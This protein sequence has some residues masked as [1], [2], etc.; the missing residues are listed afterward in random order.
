MLSFP[1]LGRPQQTLTVRGDTVSGLS[2]CNRFD[3]GLTVNGAAV[4]I[5][6]VSMT[7]MA[8]AGDVMTKEAL[9]LEGLAQ[10]R[11][12]RATGDALSLL[13]GDGAVVLQFAR[14]SSAA[15]IDATTW[16]WAS[17]PWN[18]EPPSLRIDVN[19]ATGFTGCN[20]WFANVDRAEDRLRF[21]GVGQTKMACF[22][23][24]GAAEQQFLA[25]LARVARYRLENATL[26]LFDDRG[27]EVMRLTPQ[28][29]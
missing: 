22:G 29:R 4:R 20:R 6:N 24:A 18:A 11:S 14:M 8:C 9:F 12:A 7:E 26:Q 10:T 5:A 23:P 19:D 28:E 25:N 21:V 16:V 1:D 27:A 3:G 2:G 17:G 15:E 13:D